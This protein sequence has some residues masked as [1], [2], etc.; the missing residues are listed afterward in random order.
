MILVGSCSALS[1]STAVPPILL[2]DFVS[3]EALSASSSINNKGI[4]EIRPE[5]FTLVNQFNKFFNGVTFFLT[6]A[7]I[8]SPPGAIV[9]LL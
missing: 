8:G 9:T 6:T 3:I 7:I 1:G 4:P 2:A 5:L